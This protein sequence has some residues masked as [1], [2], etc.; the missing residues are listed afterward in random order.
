MYAVRSSKSPMDEFLDVKTDFSAFTARFDHLVLEKKSA[1]HIAQK[2]HT[3]KVAELQHSAQKLRE[4]IVYSQ[5]RASDVSTQISADLKK[6]HA[7]ESMVHGLKEKLAHAHDI[8]TALS[9]S[10]DTKKA[11]VD[12]AREALKYARTHVDGQAQKDIAEATKFEMYAGLK[13]E[14][15]DED[16]LRFRFANIDASDIDKEVS[17]ELYVG[18]D[19]YRVGATDPALPLAVVSAVETHLNQ[20]GIFVVFLKQIRKALKDAIE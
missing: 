5:A 8:K 10:L 16:L 9:G 3:D 17:C 18:D 2:Q 1:L 11:N 6:F 4:A 19:M 15:V 20:H 7:M 12:A 14:S 13:V